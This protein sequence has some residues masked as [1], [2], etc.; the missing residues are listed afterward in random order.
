V[1]G[2]AML[3][4]PKDVAKLDPTGFEAAADALVSLAA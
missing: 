3:A 1:E 2:H 4:L